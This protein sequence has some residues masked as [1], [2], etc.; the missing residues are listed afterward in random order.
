[1]FGVERRLCHADPLID[2]RWHG[3]ACPHDPLQSNE[4]VHEAEPTGGI[5]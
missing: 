4:R 5:G 1:M 2:G 3:I